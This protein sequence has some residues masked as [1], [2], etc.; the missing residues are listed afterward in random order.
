MR[1]V[2]VAVVAVM[3]MAGV[4]RADTY[5]EDRPFSPFALNLWGGIAYDYVNDNGGT[6]TGSSY[7]GFN[8]GGDIGIKFTPFFGIVLMAEYQ[9]ILSFDNPMSVWEAGAGV[10]LS[11][12]RWT[13]IVIAANYARIAGP[14]YDLPGFGVKAIGFA[15]VILGF[16]PYLQI[17]YENFSG[18]VTMVNVNAGISY[19]F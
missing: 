16:G 3:L 19:S 14:N 6:L 2:K 17:A 7:L 12:S 8:F 13:Q 15:P 1:G 11:P 4:A 10:R 5:Y 9:P 18:Q